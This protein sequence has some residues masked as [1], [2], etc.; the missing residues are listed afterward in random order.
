MQAIQ[1]E[2]VALG[3]PYKKKIGKI[4][5]AVSSFANPRATQTA[6]NLIL[7]MLKGQI[8]NTNAGGVQNG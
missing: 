4:T 6:E 8:Q 3:E 7:Q 2:A 5:Y 1:N